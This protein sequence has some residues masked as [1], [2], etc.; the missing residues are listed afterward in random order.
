MPEVKGHYMVKE[1]LEFARI[2]VRKRE[3]DE[4][5]RY[6]TNMVARVVD[7]NCGERICE[8]LQP[9]KNGKVCSE[10]EGEKE[11]DRNLQPVDR[12]EGE[13]ES[14]VESRQRF[15]SSERPE[16]AVFPC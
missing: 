2:Q 8:H 9:D 1:E 3:A 10:L 12:S 15:C 4:L 16:E 11:C 13:E 6:P 7:W 5:K 14:C